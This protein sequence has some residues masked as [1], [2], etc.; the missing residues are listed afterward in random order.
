[1]TERQKNS[2]WYEGKPS[3]DRGHRI[4]VLE[5]FLVLVKLGDLD[6]VG[7]VKVGLA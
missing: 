5:F 1:M 7:N 3:N 2:N 4:H 6:G